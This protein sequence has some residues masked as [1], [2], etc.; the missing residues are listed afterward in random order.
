LSIPRG[1]ILL[2]QI[3]LTNEIPAYPQSF[4]ATC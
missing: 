1:V 2:S 3:L 4:S